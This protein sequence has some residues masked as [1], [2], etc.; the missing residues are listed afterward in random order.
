[1]TK[2]KKVNLSHNLWDLPCHSAIH[3]PKINYFPVMGKFGFSQRFGSLAEFIDRSSINRCSNFWPAPLPGEAMWQ[4]CMLTSAHCP[5]VPGLPAMWPVRPY[6]VPGISSASQDHSH[7]ESIPVG[8]SSPAR[9]AWYP[10]P[11]AQPIVPA[12]G[13]VGAPAWCHC[14]WCGHISAFITGHT[15]PTSPLSTFLPTPPAQRPKY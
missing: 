14:W 13:G 8:G 1:M 2:V 9:P 4:E 10:P 12:S 3:W 5:R 7:F 15:S 11:P 6:G